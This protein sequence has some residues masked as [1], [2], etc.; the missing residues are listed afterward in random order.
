[1]LT[2]KP[3]VT[4][5]PGAGDDCALMLAIR[6]EDDSAAFAMLVDRYW[7]RL[8]AYAAR[9]LTRQSDAEDTVQEVFIQVWKRRKD[10]APSGSVSGYLYR[11]TR[12]F[13]L[14]AIRLRQVRRRPEEAVAVEI[15]EYSAPSSPE[16][17]FESAQLRHEIESAIDALPERR[18]EVFILARYHGLTHREI[19][20]AMDISVQTVSNQMTAALAT[21]RVTLAHHLPAAELA[22]ASVLPHRAPRDPQS[23]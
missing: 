1:M 20:S 14:N 13:A 3:K 12:N 11:I 17:D 15:L 18:R 21:L 5:L 16:E 8:V 22:D 4:Q 19:A 6:D 23:Q 7:G 2:T 9:L 10:W